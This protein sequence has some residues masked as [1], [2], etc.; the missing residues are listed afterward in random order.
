MIRNRKSGKERIERSIENNRPCRPEGVSARKLRAAGRNAKDPCLGESDL[1]S[2]GGEKTALS[3]EG[4]G[5]SH[6]PF[7]YIHPQRRHK[8]ICEIVCLDYNAQEQNTNRK[9]DPQKSGNRKERLI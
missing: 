5:G 4:D 1:V 8:E 2:S 7:P 9:H 6:E 3:S